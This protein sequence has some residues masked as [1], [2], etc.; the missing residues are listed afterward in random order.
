MPFQHV[1]LARRRR[2]G[3]LLIVALTSA[4]SE[5]M[6][7]PTPALTGADPALVCNA[8]LTTTVTLSGSGM[9]PVVIDSLTGDPGLRLPNLGLTRSQELDGSAAASLTPLD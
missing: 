9:S 3:I 1:V 6:E 7:S 8:Q 4:C 2:A 5:E